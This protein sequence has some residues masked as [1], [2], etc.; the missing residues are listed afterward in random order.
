[1]RSFLIVTN[2]ISGAKKGPSLAEK[3]TSVLGEASIPSRIIFTDPLRSLKDQAVAGALGTRPPTDLMVIGGDGTLNAAINAFG[4]EWPLSI[5]PAGTGNDFVKNISVGKSLDQQIQT[6][7]HG[8]VKAIDVGICNGRRFLNG[9]G[10][11]FDGQV[12]KEMLQ[13]K[14]WMKGHL[15]YYGVVI[16]ILS[17]Y[18]EQALSLHWDETK[19]EDDLFLLTVGNG[20]TFGGGF[21]LTPNAQLDDGLLDVCVIRKIPAWRRFANIHRLSKGTHFDLEEV[22]EHRTSSLQ[23]KGSNGVAAHI[24]GEYFGHPPFDISLERQAARVRISSN[25]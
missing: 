18:R 7:L 16:K 4:D 10:V 14:T 15:A 25:R 9:V 22:T 11:G 24:D 5:I 20:T 12:V 1:M 8:Q 3:V 23:I 2:P 17:S 13:Q 19:I 6:A 21:R